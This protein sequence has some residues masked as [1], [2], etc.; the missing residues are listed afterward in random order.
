MRK[1]VLIYISILVSCFCLGA[2]DSADNGLFLDAAKE[3]ADGRYLKA[4][5]KFL[6]LLDSAPEDAAVNYYLGLCELALGENANAEAH[7]TRASQI[8]STNAWYLNALATLYGNTGD[9]ASLAD[10]CE[11]LVKMSRSLQHSLYTDA[12][13]RHPL[14]AEAGFPRARILQPGP[15]TRSGLCSGGAGEDRTPQDDRVLS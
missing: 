12:Y 4:Q 6:V 10:V 3:Y 8:D 1:I 14:P 9:R 7:L 5:E 15:R 11:R 2:Q 13:R